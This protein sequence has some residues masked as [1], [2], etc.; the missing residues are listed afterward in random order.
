MSTMKKVVNRALGIWGLQLTRVP[1]ASGTG[2][3]SALFRNKKVAD[4][5]NLVEIASIIPPDLE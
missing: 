1:H 3:Y 5:D 4:L 2:P